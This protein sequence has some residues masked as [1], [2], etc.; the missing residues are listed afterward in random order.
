VAIKTKKKK[1][2]RKKTKAGEKEKNLKNTAG[3]IEN[4]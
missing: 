4:K 1:K 3:Q 2:E